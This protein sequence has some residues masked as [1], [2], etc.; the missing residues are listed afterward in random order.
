M[1]VPFTQAFGENGQPHK[2][3]A[4][5][6]DLQRKKRGGK[7]PS[8]AQAMIDPNSKP[9]STRRKWLVRAGVVGGVVV[10]GSWAWAAHHA[11]LPLMGQLI[12]FAEASPYTP[13]AFGLGATLLPL[14]FFPETVV[15]IGSG[16]LFGLTGGVVATVATQTVGGMMAY[17]I[18]RRLKERTTEDKPLSPKLAPYIAPLQD[19]PFE[20]VLIMRLLYLPHELVSYASGWLQVDWQPYLWGTALGLIPSSIVFA[21]V[22]ASIRNGVLTN[23]SLLSPQMLLISG[24]VL[25]GGFVLAKALQQPQQEGLEGDTPL[26]LPAI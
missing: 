15:A 23:A 22:G 6:R 11:V 16:V 2:Q 9:S 26:P 17:G 1:I 13:L 14:A 21:S 3:A 20:S 7:R 8:F 12:T 25:V 4:G 10:I 18:G 5:S 24:G 19:K